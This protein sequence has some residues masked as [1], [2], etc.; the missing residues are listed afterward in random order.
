MKTIQLLFPHQLFKEL[1]FDIELPVYLVEEYL[2]FNQYLFHKQKIAFHRASMKAY[3]SK[4]QEE[5]YQVNYISAIDNGSEIRE[6]IYSLSKR[7]CEKVVCI[8]PVDFL[9]QKRLK[10]NCLKENI[11]LKQYES[12]AFFNT[13]N[14]LDLFFKSSKKKFFQTSFY[15]SERKRLGILIDSNGDPSG[16]QWSFDADNRKKYPKNK[17]VPSI[18]FP[19]SSVHYEEAKSY[20]N[21]HFDHH[22]GFLSENPRY[23][24]DR[25]SALLWLNDFFEHRFSEFGNF[26]DAI[27]QQEHILHHSVLSP[28]IN[29]GI[30]LPEEVVNGAL[31]F[32]EKNQ[33][34][35]NSTEGFVRQIIGWRE[36]IRGMYV[37]KGVEMR[38]TNYWGFKRKIPS[39]FYDGTTGI[40]PV[41]NAIKKVLETGYSH[42]IERLMVLGNFMLLCEFDPDD[43]YKWFMEM[44]I[45]AFD[46]VM[47]PNVYAMSQFADGGTMT[48]KPYI[49]GSNYLRKMS[50]YASGDWVEIWDALFWR[51]MHVHRSFFATNPRL[52]MLIGNFDKMSAEKRSALLE[53]AD[54]F[55]LRLSK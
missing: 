15:Q 1:P 35:I 43:V 12:P 19:K 29:V 32:A 36:F 39:S 2:F 52:G 45:D 37:C 13:P 44:Y 14:S 24:I 9:L 33:V 30:L 38:T 8:D 41:D 20:V 27:L 51:F 46:W 18:Q 16:K 40:L 4:L 42:H 48:T 34:P 3:A 17:T 22:H 47:V 55:L 31:T 21:A 10:N 23:P 11:E 53:K 25:P 50:D 54:N 26:E 5:G 28:L 7:K 6:L 49:S